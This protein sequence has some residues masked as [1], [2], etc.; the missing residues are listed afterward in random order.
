MLKE[1]NLNYFNALN[2][3]IT[4]VTEDGSIWVNFNKN[5]GRLVIECRHGILDSA[6]LKDFK[7]M[8]FD[9]INHE[10]FVVYINFLFFCNLMDEDTLDM[11]IPMGLIP[12]VKTTLALPLEVLD[13]QTTFLPRTPGK[14][15]SMVI[16]NKLE[17]NR[18]NC[19]ALGTMKCFKNPLIEIS[20][21][22]LTDSEPDYPLPDMKLVDELGQW[23][24]RI[25]PGKTS[26]EQELKDYLLTELELSNNLK[27]LDDRS[28]YGGWKK[29]R[30]DASGYFQTHHDGKRWWLVDPEGYGFL[31]IGIDSVVPGEA[32]RIDG[33]QKFFDWLPEKDSIYKP[34][35]KTGERVD[36]SEYYNFAVS[37]LIR[38][39]GD[40]WWDNW[41]KL[42][43]GRLL[44]WG[45]NTAG[46]WSSHDFIRFAKIPYVWP[47]SGFPGTKN[48]IFRD[49]PDVFSKEYEMNSAKFA[50]QLKAFEGDRYLI[51][52]FLCNE[53]KWAF[54]D[55]LNIAE[56][57]LENEKD[58]VSKD[59]LIQFLSDRYSG[60][61][62]SF[63]TA[64]NLKLPCF[65]QLKGKIRRA[66]S[67]SEASNN[68]L[69]EFSK[70]MISL[71]SEIP[72]KACKSVDPY[73]LNLGMRYAWID[74]DIL[75]AGSENFDIFSF[76]CYKMNPAD[77]IINIGKKTNL[78]VMIG[79]YHFGALDR[80]LLSTGL[81][82]VASQEERGKAYRFY[83]ENA[84]SVEYCVG[85]HY[86]ILNDQ[87]VLGRFDG[88]N[89]QIGCVDVCHRPYEEFV[90]AA[91]ESNRIIY[92]VSSKIRKA[93][94]THAQEIPKN[95][96]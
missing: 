96:T 85:A 55:N 4:K 37:N 23:K 21:C 82:G 80:G 73:H 92:E 27:S 59:Y 48:R 38:V 63:N 39:F 40:Q 76:N 15:K 13:S 29:C 68:D 74:N 41:A 91:S 7:Y 31:S 45:F 62:V 54:V 86:F 64:W 49:F 44:K 10:E 24:K 84:L 43:R 88:E 93:W 16:G 47:L 71:F 66:S 18:I 58:F 77:D 75:F 60:D 90:Q 17:L 50:Q 2:C 95:A 83:V 9:A 81:R 12:G 22:R 61:I 11:V 56:E 20:N 46:N 25:W 8:V 70:R 57:L 32:G 35:W 28:S 72:S 42:T 67:L 89:F 14:L 69:N 3:E 26:N 52:Y 51:G 6:N 65:E 79:E 34:A 33:L 19:F 1:V 87:A 78:P 53:P 30:L 36:H 94:D 5:G